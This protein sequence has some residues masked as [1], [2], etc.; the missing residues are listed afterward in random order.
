MRRPARQC[1][2]P[3]HVSRGFLCRGPRGDCGVR[4]VLVSPFEAC[5]CW[6]GLLNGVLLVAM[7][8][9]RGKLLTGMTFEKASTSQLIFKL[10]RFQLQVASKFQ[11]QFTSCKSIESITEE[12]NSSFPQ[13]TMS[14][15][16]FRVL[17]GA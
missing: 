11:L 15:S 9:V 7:L 17:A 3:R 10:L 8:K 14:S 12:Y 2:G 13:Y 1:N 5:P 4:I 16:T 6:K